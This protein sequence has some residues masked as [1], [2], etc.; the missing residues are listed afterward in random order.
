[1]SI[2]SQIKI[3]FLTSI[4]MIEEKEAKL[5]TLH[6][7][8]KAK[9]KNFK[10]Q[11]LKDL[12]ILGLIKHQITQIKIERNELQSQYPKLLNTSN[13]Y[14]AGFPIYCDETIENDPKLTLNTIKLLEVSAIHTGLKMTMDANK[15]EFKRY[16]KLLEKEIMQ[17]N[18]ELQVIYIS[19]KNIN[20]VCTKT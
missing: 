13:N 15:Y 7:E 11:N 18:A 3:N 4:Q 5:A 8:I 16:N 12:S 17:T 6:A 19:C 10:N 1:M 14:V 2:A 20:N 9:K